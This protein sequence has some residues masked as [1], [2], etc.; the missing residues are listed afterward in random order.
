[1]MFQTESAATYQAFRMNML[2]DQL[3]VSGWLL[4]G[5]TLQSLVTV[6]ILPSAPKYVW[7]PAILLVGFKVANTLLILAGAKRNPAM[8]GVD[9]GRVSPVSL[10]QLGQYL[11]SYACR[12]LT[13]TLKELI[14]SSVSSL[15]C[16]AISK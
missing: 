3:S 8:Q 9:M 15:V 2:R 1:M 16:N 10:R 4:L 7:L 13:R 12:T 11:C 14:E 5:A 6:S